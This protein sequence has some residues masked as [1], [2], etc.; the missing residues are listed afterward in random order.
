MKIV[1][2]SFILFSFISSISA[3]T[4][5]I[6]YQVTVNPYSYT[7]KR[8]VYK[9]IL[10]GTSSLYYND[11]ND[12]NIFPYID[13]E[14]EIIK[15]KK[16]VKT[17]KIDD[18]HIVKIMQEYLYKNYNTEIIIY[19]KPLVFSEIL[20]IKEPLQLFTWQII[21]NVDTLI[22]GYHC[23]KAKASFRGREYTAYFSPEINMF[24]GPWKFDGL[25]G[26]ILS[27]KDE[28]EY[29]IIEPIKL[30]VSENNVPIKN[31][32]VKERDIIT[33]DE[34]TQAYFKKMKDIL[35]LS[36]ANSSA[37]ETT[38]LI[39]KSGIEDLGFKQLSTDD[40]KN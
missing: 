39:I 8:S 7:C 20:V 16:G 21:P 3:Q 23:Q 1:F 34:Y 30:S 29:F 19:N 5:N 18:G 35:K 17:V 25:P 12:I 14:P 37:G 10:S 22:L 4:I 2:F 15:E 40:L 26:L 6:D 31:P 38:K 32:F 24:G 9:Y 27:V 33:W 28:D 11:V 36:K 13:W